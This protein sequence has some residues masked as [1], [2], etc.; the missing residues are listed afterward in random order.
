MTK[1]QAKRWVA[2]R[3]SRST[4]AGLLEDEATDLPEPDRKRVDE[5]AEALQ[6][7]LTRRAKGSEEP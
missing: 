4:R 6:V 7:E 2:E 3:V 5:A 1:A